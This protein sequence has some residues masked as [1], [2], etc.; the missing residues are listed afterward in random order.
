[1]RQL[2]D[3]R[4]QAMVEFAII[5][6]FFAV[7]LYIIAYGSMLFHDF[8]TLTELARDI[9]RRESVGIVYDQARYNNTA[10]LT[11]L[12]TLNLARDEGVLIELITDDITGRQVVVTV[13]AQL[14]LPNRFWENML[15]NTISASLTMHR[16]E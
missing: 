15:P 3:K 16:E 12:Y 9:A 10:L 2:L 7:L 13:T 6:P 11:D 1:M 4:G 8:I 14:N 5:I